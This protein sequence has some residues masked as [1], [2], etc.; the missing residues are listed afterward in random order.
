MVVAV[1]T[2]T[3]A[4]F[5][6][7]ISPAAEPGSGAMI[8]LLAADAQE[9]LVGE[10]LVRQVAG[11]GKSCADF[12]RALRDIAGFRLLGESVSAGDEAAELVLAVQCR[13]SRWSSKC[14]C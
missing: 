14:C 9:L 5:L 4:E 11:A 3:P 10:V 8:D 1:P 13:C 7:V 12:D 6:T 2:I